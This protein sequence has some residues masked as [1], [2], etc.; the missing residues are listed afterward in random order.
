[1]SDL[2]AR[3]PRQNLGPRLVAAAE[4]FYDLSEGTIFSSRRRGR[5]SLAR[6]ALCHVLVEHVGWSLNRTGK[7]I[8]KDHKAVA[9]GCAKA[10]ELLRTD[11]VFFEAVRYLRGL[12]APE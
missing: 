3:G 12:V 7:M 4:H 9:L 11:P 8:D 10:K 6:W 1:L 2:T 5:P